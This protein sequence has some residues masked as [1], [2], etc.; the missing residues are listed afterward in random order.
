MSSGGI[1]DRLEDAGVTIAASLPDQ[2]L[3]G[4]LDAID[5]SKTILHVPVGR[6][7]EGVGICLGAHLG[8]TL[9][10]LVC[11][12]AGLLLAVNALAGAARYHHAPMVVLVAYRGHS[13]DPYPYQAYKGEVTEPVLAALDLPYWTATGS[14]DI[15]MVSAAGAAAVGSRGPAVVLLTHNALQEESS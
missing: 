3:G 11:Q 2:W 5:D 13:G 1:V 12:N 10:A 15:D 4:V 9:G 14:E 8:G 7:E 6:E